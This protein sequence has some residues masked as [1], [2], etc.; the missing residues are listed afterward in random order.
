VIHL[1]DKA[2][3]NSSQTYKTF[4][5]SKFK[6]Q[7]GEIV[8]EI[9]PEDQPYRRFK[10][11]ETGISPRAFLGTKDVVQW[12]T[13]D[14]HNEIG[15]IS[16]EPFNRDKMVEKRMKKLELVEEE[17]PIEEK[18]NFYGDKGSQNLIL[19]WGSPK[20]AILEALD[21]LKG[22]GFN[23]G[24]VQARMLLPLPSDYFTNL[25]K[26][27]EKIID[28]ENNYLGQLGGVVKQE[29]GITPN[30]YVLK[31]NGR[32]ISTTELYHAL[33]NILVGQAPKRQVLT[34]G[35]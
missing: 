11:T 1:I 22:E 35:S 23:L 21:M 34:Y 26:T 31:Y 9:K 10:F 18:I 19:S 5:A 15:H 12:Y 7:R 24:F 4:D 17:I 8:T 28:V 13:G 6:V 16:E 32:P 14:E 25:F 33:K 30:F 3:A 27:S 29:T 20:G 2:M